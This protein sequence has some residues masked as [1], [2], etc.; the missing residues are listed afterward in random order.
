ML[1]KKNLPLLLIIVLFITSCSKELEF[2][3]PP[4]NPSSVTV[5]L[6]AG[7]GTPGSVNGT[8]N[9]ASFYQPTGVAV[10]ASGNVYVADFR[11]SLIREISQAGV[12]TTFAGGVNAGSANGTGIYASFNEPTGVATDGAGNIYVADNGNNLIRE[13]S[14][15]GV[16]TTLAG[17]GAQGSANGPA[18][19]ASFNFPQGV[20]VD[21]AGNVY[22]ADYGNNM[23]RKISAAGSVTTLAGRDSSGSTNGVDT[24]ATFNQPSGVAVDAGGNVYVADFGN[25]LIRKI[26]QTGGVSTFAGSGTPGA[27][28]GT[29]AA[30]SFNG[31][32]GLAIDASGNVYVADYGNN[33]IRKITPAGVVTTIG[34]GAA[35][36]GNTLFNGPYGV[37]VDAAGNIYV[38]NYRNSTIQKISK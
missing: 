33:L 37:A 4:V 19:A 31:P 27:A 13:I 28:N 8:G 11:N 2:N 20:A 22:V 21:A 6:L 1:T 15:S 10:D 30:A 32:T 5:S 7:S 16:V 38:A 34:N 17:T 35:G 25:N 12:V 3:T 26:S 18:A 29:G 14:P 23:I 36:T 9:A 24:A